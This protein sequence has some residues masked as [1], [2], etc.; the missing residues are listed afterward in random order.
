MKATRTFGKT[1]VKG[2]IID[3]SNGQSYPFE[4]ETEYTRSAEK[5]Q[6]LVNVEELGFVDGNYAIA[7]TELVNEKAE[8]KRYSNSKI[9]DMAINVFNDEEDAKEA[10]EIKNAIVRKVSMY[11]YDAQIWARKDNGEYF[12]E[13]FTDESPI[14]MT[15]LDARAF[16]TMMAESY[17]DCKVIGIHEAEKTELQKFAVIFADE[18]AKCIITK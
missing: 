16:L 13:S 14:N 8:A 6:K 7:I 18:L 1:Q 4:C 11:Q 3:L 9:I 10:A 2:F 15:K 17:F 12:T 5:A